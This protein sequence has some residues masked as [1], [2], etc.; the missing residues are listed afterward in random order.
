MLAHDIAG[1]KET[2]RASFYIYNME[3]EINIFVKLLRGFLSAAA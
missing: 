1:I 2:V 3:E